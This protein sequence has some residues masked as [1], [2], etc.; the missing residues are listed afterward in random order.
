MT[1]LHYPKRE[2]RCPHCGSTA[3]PNMVLS[4]TDEASGIIFRDYRCGCGCEFRI[5]LG[6]VKVETLKKGKE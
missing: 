5:T 2:L 4:V 1:D 6:I 3:Q